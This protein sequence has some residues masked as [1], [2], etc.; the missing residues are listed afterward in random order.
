MH[1][2]YFL[3]VSVN[4]SKVLFKQNLADKS[5]ILLAKVT[6]FYENPNFFLYLRY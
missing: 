1:L 6:H 3:K 2:V 5:Q 4:A